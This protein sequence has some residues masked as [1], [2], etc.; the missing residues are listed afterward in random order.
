MFSSEVVLAV[1]VLLSLN[2]YQESAPDEKCAKTKDVAFLASGNTMR[3]AILRKVL[4]KLWTE[5]YISVKLGNP[6]KYAL[7]KDPNEIT[8]L[9][10]IQLFHGDICIGEGYDHY[11]ARGHENIPTQSYVLFWLYEKKLYQQLRDE[12]ET[13]PITRF[14]QPATPVRITPSNTQSQDAQLMVGNSDLL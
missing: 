3:K 6:K 12:F 4:R 7:V 1:E 10:L 11:L 13:M 2:K 8:V 14:K 9:N 5:R